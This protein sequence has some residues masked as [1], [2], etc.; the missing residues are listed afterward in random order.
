MDREQHETTGVGYH[1]Y[2]WGSVGLMRVVHD[3]YRA[4]GRGPCSVMAHRISALPI[5]WLLHGLLLHGCCTQK[6]HLH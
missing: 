6:G 1:D 3:W 4:L 2:N 5:T